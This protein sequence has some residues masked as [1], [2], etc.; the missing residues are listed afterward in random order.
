MKK[1]TALKSFTVNAMI[2]VAVSK[3]V[4]ARDAKHAREIADDLYVPSLCSQC[5]RERSDDTWSL[6]G[7]DS[8]ATNIVVVE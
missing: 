5:C 6:S 8:D 3:V 1:S 4:M 7:I 2:T